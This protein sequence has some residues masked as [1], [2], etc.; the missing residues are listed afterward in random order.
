MQAYVYYIYAYICIMHSLFI[1]LPFFLQL[2]NF[3][4]I[5]NFVAQS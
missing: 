1:Y 4:L 2:K 3:E 5:K